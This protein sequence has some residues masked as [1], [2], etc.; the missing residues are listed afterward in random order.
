MLIM[1]IIFCCIFLV[2]SLGCFFY[3]V[4][5]SVYGVLCDTVRV[6]GCLGGWWC[7]GVGFWLVGVFVFVFALSFGFVFVFVVFLEI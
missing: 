3:F 7:S 1:N 2:P 4:R 6:I 5:L